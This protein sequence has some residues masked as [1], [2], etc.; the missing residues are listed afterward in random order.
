MPYLI[1]TVT[2]F[3][4]NCTLL[5]SDD[6]RSSAIIDPGGDLELIKDAIREHQLIP[7]VIL[8]THAHIDHVGGANQLRT[9]LGIPI[10]GPHIEDRIWLDKLP[11][12]SE[13]FGFERAEPFMPDEWLQQG[14]ILNLGEMKLEV[15]HC[16]GHTP[17]HLVFYVPDENTVFVGDVLFRGA[18]GRTDFP[19]GDHQALLTSIRTQLWPLGDQV[20]VVPGHGPE[21]TIGMERRTNPFLND[22]V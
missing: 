5:W 2:P 8:L 16:P 6:N 11:D 4:Q 14:S 18:I 17:G 13:L 20:R 21:T 10:K 19:L 12:Q 1:Q 15:L 7:E 3:E 22:R 9:E